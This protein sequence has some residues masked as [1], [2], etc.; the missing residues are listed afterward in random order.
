MGIRALLEQVMIGEI[1]DQGRFTDNLATFEK[2]GFVSPKQSETLGTVL[3]LGH[4]AIHRNYSPSLKEIVAALDITEAILESVY[5]H[6][7]LA[8]EIKKRVPPR[9]KTQRPKKKETKSP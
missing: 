6:G 7:K 9:K 1:E 3:E 5:R 4:A 8:D 2:E